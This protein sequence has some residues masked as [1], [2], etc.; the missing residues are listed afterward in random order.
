[1]VS[2]GSSAVQTAAPC[3]SHMSVCLCPYTHAL[4]ASG[5]SG[6]T[7][8]LLSPN[9]HRHG[10]STGQWVSADPDDSFLAVP[11]CS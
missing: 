1:M 9:T 10:T 5:Y 7:E 8:A 4:E 2:A 3:A 6:R 11:A